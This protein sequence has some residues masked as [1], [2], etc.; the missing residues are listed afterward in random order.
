MLRPKTEASHPRW[1]AL[2]YARHSADG[3]RL[4]AN[5][6]RK[7]YTAIW[8]SRRTFKTFRTLRERISKRCD[9][10]LIGLALELATNMLHAV[11]HVLCKRL[12][13]M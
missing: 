10:A 12:V 2:S 5:Y 6:L 3:A 1:T 4:S 13:F 8:T 11:A 9:A 7:N